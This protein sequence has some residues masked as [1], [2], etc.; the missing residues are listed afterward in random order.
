MS[1][2][3]TLVAAGVSKSYGAQVVLADVDLVVPPRAR[4]GL[5]GPNGVGKSTLLLLLAGAEE[6]DRGGVRRTPRAL[7]VGRLPQERDLRRR[8]DAARLPGAQDRGRRGRGAAGRARGSPRRRARARR[9]ARR[10][11]RGV[12]RPGRRRSRGAGCDDIGRARAP[13]PA[14]AHAGGPIGRG[15]GAGGPRLDPAQP[16]RRAPA[17]RADERPRFRRPRATRRVPRRVRG[18]GRRRL[19]R[20]RVPRS[21]GDAGRR[22]RRVDARRA[23]VRRRLERVR[24]GAGAAAGARLRALGGLRRRAG[25]DRRAGAAHDRVGAPRLRPGTQ[26]EE[27]EGRQ[28]GICEAARSPRRG[29][30]ALRAVGAAARPRPL[31]AKRRRGRSARGSGGAPWHVLPRSSRPRRPVGRPCGARRGRTGPARRRCST[32]C[33]ASCR[34][35]RARAG[36]APESSS[37]SSSR[38]GR[39]STTTRAFS[40]CSSRSVGA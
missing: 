28:E 29:R 40:R 1:R 17:R 2:V 34:S 12:P 20:P 5:V 32:S 38:T 22:A 16:V 7:A 35:R 4:I 13:D 21:D 14:R 36:W 33:S 11:S 15:G 30:E 9:R 6:P 10:G 18:I 25:A 24:G 26:E 27:D 19:A 31:R 8:R 23:G 37:A 3:G 39:G